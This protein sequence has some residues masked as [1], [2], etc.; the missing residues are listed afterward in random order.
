M[1]TFVHVDP[2]GSFGF[3]TS[4]GSLLLV[5]PGKPLDT[6]DPAVAAYLDTVPFVKRAGSKAKADPSGGEEA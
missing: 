6:D 2:D 1:A 3:H 5:E 4:D